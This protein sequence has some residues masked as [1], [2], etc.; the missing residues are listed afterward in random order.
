MVSL[1]EKVDA[2]LDESPEF[3]DHLKENTTVTAYLGI[4]GEGNS[5]YLV[6]FEQHSENFCYVI[7]VG[8]NIPGIK[9]KHNGE[10]MIR[11]YQILDEE[12]PRIETYRTK[13]E[14]GSFSATARFHEALA[15]LAE[16]TSLAR[17][18][19]LIYLEKTQCISEENTIKLLFEVTGQKY[20]T[21]YPG[22]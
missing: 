7:E 5:F 11:T 16:N 6:A 10:N 21:R 22:M 14:L 18:N 3:K 4:N 13:S 15:F 20:F 2:I 19:D 9:A 1:L 17:T 8:K 12:K